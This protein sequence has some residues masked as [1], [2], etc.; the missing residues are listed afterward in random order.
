MKSEAAAALCGPVTLETGNE[1]HYSDMLQPLT[2]Q[3]AARP[4]GEVASFLRPR[5]LHK[6]P[7]SATNCLNVAAEEIRAAARGLS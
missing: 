7:P 4:R 1:L 2:S 5:L 3:E 6:V